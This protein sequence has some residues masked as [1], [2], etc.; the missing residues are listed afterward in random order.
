[1]G[2]GGCLGSSLG[3]MTVDVAVGRKD[4]RDERPRRSVSLTGNATTHFR[5]LRRLLGTGTR[6]AHRM[7]EFRYIYMTTWLSE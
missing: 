5:N 7:D 3:F 2:G 4:Y 6:Q 1:M